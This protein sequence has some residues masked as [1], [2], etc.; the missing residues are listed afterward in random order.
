MDSCPTGQNTYEW[1]TVML[2]ALLDNRRLLVLLLFLA[3]IVLAALTA[4]HALSP[5]GPHHLLG[6]TDSPDVIVHNH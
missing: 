5:I 6:L 2:L 1:R 4:L 3:L